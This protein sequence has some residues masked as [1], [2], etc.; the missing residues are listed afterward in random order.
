MNIYKYTKK[1]M[2]L[3]FNLA[4]FNINLVYCKTTLNSVNCFL[5]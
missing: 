1:Q 2:Q 5:Y 4:L 3:A